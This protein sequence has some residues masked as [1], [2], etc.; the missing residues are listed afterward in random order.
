MISRTSSRWVRQGGAVLVGLMATVA[1][2][3]Q[4]P[5]I[6]LADLSL[7]GQ[8]AAPTTGE[9]LAGAEVLLATN[10][11][12]TPV[13]GGYLMA[14]DPWTR[15]HGGLDSKLICDPMEDF[16]GQPTIARPPG[17]VKGCSG[18]L[19]APNLV[20]TAGHCI[21]DPQGPSNPAPYDCPN[22]WVIFDYADQA[23]ISGPGTV[24]IP[25]DNAVRCSRV[26]VDTSSSLNEDIQQ[27]ELTL[28]AD[29]ALIELVA[30]VEDRLPMVVERHPQTELGDP[31]LIL[32]HPARIPMK[33]EISTVTTAGLRTNL[34][35]LGGSS[36]SPMVNL[37]TGK[38]F[39][40]ATNV[41]DGYPWITIL[42]GPPLDGCAE[43]CFEC[44]GDTTS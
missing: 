15:L 28:G 12:L 39:S 17:G 38:V 37:R 43:L 13:S 36:G 25:S 14:V 23:P 24:F 34:H 35:V 6:E 31:V 11:D 7:A 16:Y 26:L 1:N 29:W 19:V 22:R 2:A 5:W 32:G 20:V 27:S 40:N 42:G 8:T 41:H 3:Q 30:D 44:D 10:A 9:R 33:A 21:N 4:L 18:F